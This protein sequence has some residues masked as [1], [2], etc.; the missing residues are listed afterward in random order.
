M[1]LLLLSAA[2]RCGNIR[3]ALRDRRKR[4]RE[5][6]GRVY[7]GGFSL[8]LEEEEEGTSVRGIGDF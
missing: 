4:E 2:A 5:S 3:F 7:V 8:F 6:T 1:L